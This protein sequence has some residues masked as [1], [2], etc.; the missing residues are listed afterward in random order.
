ML[1][2][3]VRATSQVER[4]AIEPLLGLRQNWQQ[5]SLLVLVNAFVGAMVGLERAVLPLWAAADFGLASK[6]AILSFIVAFGVVKAVTN[7]V[8]GRQAERVGRKSLLVAGWLVGLPIPFML[9]WAPS[10]A[11]VTAANMLLGI[12]QGLCWSTTVVM[13]IDLAGPRRRGLAMGL[14]EFAGYGAVA[15]VTWIGAIAADAYGFRSSLFVLGLGFSIVGLL[16][17]MFLVRDTIAFAESEARS[18]SRVR[19]S[20]SFR[21]VFVQTSVR[22]RSLSACSQAG[23][24]NNLND[25]L[26][27]GLFPLLFA[28]AGLTVGNIGLLAGVYPAVWSVS[29]IATGALSDRWGRKWPIVAGMWI[30]AIGIWLVASGSTVTHPFALWVTGSV[31]LGVGTAL[32]YPALLAAIGDRADPRWRASAVGVYRF[33]R[34]MGYAVGAILSGVLADRLGIGPAIAAIGFLTFASGVVVA[35]RMVD[36]RVD[37]GSLGKET[38]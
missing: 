13:K 9:L 23:L 20:T 8:A 32:V 2:Q 29:Q 38:V 7:L 34:D 31:L 15:L 33:W 26:A 19:T 10:W 17:S 37:V 18:R 25:G 6:S 3:Y 16:L 24:V 12:N 28:S 14:N 4:V 30:Q 21:W 36:S 11:W 5:F 22:D 27:W 35:I 1:P